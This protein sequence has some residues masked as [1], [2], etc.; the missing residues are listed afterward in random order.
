MLHCLILF[1]APQPAPT[2]ATLTSPPAVARP[3]SWL[4]VGA[5]RR[6]RFVAAVLGNMLGL[7]ALL[8]GSWGFLLLLQD[9]LSTL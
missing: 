6:W 5:K 7:A 8:L 2:Q 9:L 4:P 3:E 1:L